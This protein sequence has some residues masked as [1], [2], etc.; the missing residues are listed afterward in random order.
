MEQSQN[1]HLEGCRCEF[2]FHYYGVSLF[3][4]SILHVQM[5]ADDTGACLHIYGS[6]WVAE[7]IFQFLM[8]PQDERCRK[9][10]Q[11]PTH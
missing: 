4:L 6:T 8:L 10:S 5:R 11:C 3:H 2:R 1:Q 7:N 9:F